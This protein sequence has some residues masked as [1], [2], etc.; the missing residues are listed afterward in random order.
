MA[1]VA[2]EGDERPKGTDFTFLNRTFS[3]KYLSAEIDVGPGCRRS[4]NCCMC[5][6]LTLAGGHAC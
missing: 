5:L 1:V 3:N 4:S 6:V 2:D